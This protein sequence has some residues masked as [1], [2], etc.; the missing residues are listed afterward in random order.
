M[1]SHNKETIIIGDNEENI[2]PEEQQ[3]I[4]L[5]NRGR[6]IKLSDIVYVSCMHAWSL[7]TSIMNGERLSQALL[8]AT[9]SRAVFVRVLLQEMEQSSCTNQLL[10]KKMCFGLLIQR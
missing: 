9:N 5:I 8:S 2:V 10:N 1:L 3:Y 4:S 7:Y 6:L